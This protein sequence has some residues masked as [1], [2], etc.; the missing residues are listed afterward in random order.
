MRAPGAVL[1][2]RMMLGSKISRLLGYS[3]ELQT[4]GSPW[5]CEESNVTLGRW[6]LID[7]EQDFSPRIGVTADR[8]GTSEQ[9]LSSGPEA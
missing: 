7:G 4:P 5:S 9:V 2:P 3:I 8:V 1:K 6:Y